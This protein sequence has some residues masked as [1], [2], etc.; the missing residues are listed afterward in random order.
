[1]YPNIPLPPEPIITRWGSWI[2]AAIYYADNFDAIFEI[3]DSL[4]ARDAEC[5][6]IAQQLI[7]KTN[8][9]MDL[10]FIKCNF[11]IIP[12]SIAKLQYK[13]LKIDKALEYFENVRENIV[14]LPNDN[15]LKKFDAVVYRNPDI[16]SAK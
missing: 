12:K 5:I 13:M 1:M 4:D 14:N 3:L 2:A 16:E 10:A 6:R 9:K 15:F 11:E 8:L 7:S